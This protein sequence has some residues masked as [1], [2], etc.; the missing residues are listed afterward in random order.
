MAKKKL[1][2]Q[3]ILDDP[4]QLAD[5]QKK[6]SR[7]M[8]AATFAANPENSKNSHAKRL[9]TLAAN[10]DIVK[11]SVAKRLATLAANPDIVKKIVTKRAATLAKNPEIMKKRADNIKATLAAN[12][13]IFKNSV[14][15]R[16]VTLAKKQ[17][18]HTPY[19][20][21]TFLRQ[22]ARELVGKHGFSNSYD[23]MIIKIHRLKKTNP[24]EWYWVKKT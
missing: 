1:D 11:K 21:F 6:A 16:K 13:D 12:S 5:L 19:G 17:A 23:Y 14:K 9:A 22:A 18:L 20:K 15:K 24:K 8:A 10:P 2:L 7:R 4:E 3:A